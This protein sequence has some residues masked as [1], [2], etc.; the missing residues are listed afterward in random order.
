[1]YKNTIV[2]KV[3]RNKVQKVRLILAF[4]LLFMS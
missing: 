2:F 3:T 4:S 1:M